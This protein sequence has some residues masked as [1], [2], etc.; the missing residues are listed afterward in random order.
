MRIPAGVEVTVGSDEVTVKGPKGQLAYPVPKGLAVEQ[1]EGSLSVVQDGKA[2]KRDWGSLRAHLA[3]AV[4]GVSVGFTYPLLLEGPG[5]RARL[6]GKT[7]M[8]RAG[9]SWEV[10]IE[11]PEGLEVE[12]TKTGLE[13][14]GHDRQAVG[15]LADRI[16]KV[17]PADAYKLQGIRRADVEM[18]KKKRRVVE[19]V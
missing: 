6:Q 16:V 13:V 7:L 5:F 18:T 15:A 3:N 4:T 19:A 14:K 10:P 9:H 2:R 17:R 12:V 11:V 8:L 1:A